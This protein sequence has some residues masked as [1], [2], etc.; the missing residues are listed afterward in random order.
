VA[1]N[2]VDFL[3]VQGPNRQANWKTFY[4][5][6]IKKKKKALATCLNARKEKTVEV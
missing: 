5:S 6:K 2:L 4:Q 3:K 1:P